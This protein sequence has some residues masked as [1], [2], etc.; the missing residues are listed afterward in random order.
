MDYIRYNGDLVVLTSLIL[1]TGA[2]FSAITV[3]LFN[4]IGW[5]IEKFYFDF[6]AVWG[7]VSAPIVA[8]YIIKN[9][10]LITNKIAP[11]IANI[12]SPLV[13]IML[14]IYL[15]SIPFSGKDPYN[16]REFL[17]VFNLLLLGVMAIIVFSVSESSKSKEKQ[18]KKHI[19]FLMASAALIIDMVAISAILYRLGEYGFTPNRTAVLGSNVLLLG[20]LVWMTIS[21]FRVTFKNKDIELVENTVSRYLPV[22]GVW[23]VFVVFL[24]PLIFGW[25]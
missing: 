17:L 10:A 7:L 24:F 25:K 9:H 11:I 4:L 15:I 20:H 18:F 12:F 16:D 23:T 14:V 13:L 3:G 5:Q 19:L 8:T 6:I 22:Y 21:L 1:I 2:I